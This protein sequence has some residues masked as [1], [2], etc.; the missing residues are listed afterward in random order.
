MH[1]QVQSLIKGPNKLAV[2][3]H[4]CKRVLADKNI[5]ELDKNNVEQTKPLVI[6]EKQSTGAV[7]LIFPVCSVT[8]KYIYL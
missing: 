4:D 6:C 2:I 1:C 7:C 3:S 5:S 8:E